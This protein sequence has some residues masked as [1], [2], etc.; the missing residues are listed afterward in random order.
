MGVPAVSHAAV[1]ISSLSQGQLFPFVGGHHDHMLAHVD[2]DRLVPRSVV[3]AVRAV[4]LSRAR[5]QIAD[6]GGDGR[7]LLWKWSRLGP[8]LRYPVRD[9]GY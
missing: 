5:D 2:S 9:G 8:R 7:Y 3:D 6:V 4:F 1:A